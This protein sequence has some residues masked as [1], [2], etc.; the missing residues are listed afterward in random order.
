M[1]H[2]SLVLALEE[3]LSQCFAMDGQVPCASDSPGE[4]IKHSDSKLFPIPLYQAL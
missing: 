2:R 1:E 3:L 4:V